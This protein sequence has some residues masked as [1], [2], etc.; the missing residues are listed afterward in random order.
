MLPYPTWF[1]VVILI[2]ISVA[3]YL[4][5]RSPSRRELAN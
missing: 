3:I 2:A 1:K 5:L 4:G